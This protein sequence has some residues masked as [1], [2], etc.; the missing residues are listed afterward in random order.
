MEEHP[1]HIDIRLRRAFRLLTS[2]VPTPAEASILTKMYNEQR[3]HF[4]QSP[5]DAIAL[6]D[7]GMSPRDSELPVDD[8]AAMTIVVEA[9]MN[10]DECMMKH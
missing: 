6:L 4:T 8:H 1:D 7:T 9:L 5:E 10:F 3:E 2:R